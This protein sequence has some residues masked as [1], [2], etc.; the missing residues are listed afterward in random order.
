MSRISLVLAGVMLCVGILM[1]AS[2]VRAEIPQVISYQGK[3]TDTSGNPKMV[4]SSA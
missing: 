2:V 4:M 1:P 3:V